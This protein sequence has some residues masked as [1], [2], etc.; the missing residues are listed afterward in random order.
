M[1]AAIQA[2]R[3]QPLV[4]IVDDDPS[5]LS[6]LSDDIDGHGCRVEAVSSGEAAVR[7]VQRRPF[8]D[9]VL[10]DLSMPAMDGLVTLEQIRRVQPNVRVVML[11]SGDDPRKVVRSVRL[12]AED[13][14]S[15][16]HAGSGIQT[17]LGHQYAPL[18][19][20]AVSPNIEEALIDGSFFVASSPAM[21]KLRTLANEVARTDIP[22]L[23][24]GESGTGKEVIARL[25]HVL[26]HRR[27]YPFLKV[28][29]AALPN[30]LLES[31]LFGYEQGAF[32]G[33]VRSKPGKFELCARGTILLDELGEM[34]PQLQAKLLHVLQDGEF[35]RLGGRVKVKADVRVIAATNIDIDAALKTKQLREDLYYRLS[36]VVFEVPPLRDRRNEVPILLHHFAKKYGG[37]SGLPTRPVSTTVMDFAMSYDWPGNVR[38]LENFVKRFLALG[39]QALTNGNGEHR[40][41]GPVD[42]HG[43]HTESDLPPSLKVHVTSVKHDAEVLAILKALDRTNWNRKQAAKL[44]DISYKALLNKIRI[45]GLELDS[46]SSQSR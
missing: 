3:E 5:E 37:Q 4:L 8:P 17:L 35:T 39:E 46:N 23:C 19:G 18:D 45:Y 43:A 7:R 27:R 42:H 32:T 10:L 11:S 34:P 31:E 6:R 29:C 38:E 25:V 14:L 44:L 16:Q 41:K 28:N 33:A 13:C 15:K 40:A 26:S 24:L 21:R 9:L 2:V 36:A 1:Y 20:D 12:G 30:E 22:I